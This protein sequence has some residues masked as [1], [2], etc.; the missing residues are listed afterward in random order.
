[1]LEKFKQIAVQLVGEGGEETV[2]NR[3]SWPAA[4]VDLEEEFRTFVGV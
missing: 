4:I 1:M 3:G 2:W